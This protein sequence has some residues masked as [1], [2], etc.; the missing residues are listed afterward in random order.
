MGTTSFYALPYPDP[1]ST[2]DVPRDIK[3]LADKL[4][5]WKNGFTVPTGNLN[6][7]DATSGTVFAMFMNRLVA[8]TNVNW[9]WTVDDN[10]GMRLTRLNNGVPAN[11]GFIINADGTLSNFNGANSWNIKPVPFATYIGTVPINMGSAVLQTVT[12][13]YPNNR[14]T[15]A[16]LN[17]AAAQHASGLYYA[18]VGAQA[19]GSTQVIVRHADALATASNVGVNL[20]AAQAT[21]TAAP[22]LALSDVD[23][24]HSV[25]VC[26]TEDCDNAGYELPVEQVEPG[27]VVCGVC[28][29]DIDDLV[30]T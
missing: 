18:C 15:V 24:I 23:I 2:V 13:V 17:V 30:T 10:G 3:A 4:E 20:W 6:V 29:N 14:F 28:F 5:L 21:P 9:S 26:H 8:A 19:V 16:P 27:R 25:A 11:I 7:G 1:G 12:F 22:S